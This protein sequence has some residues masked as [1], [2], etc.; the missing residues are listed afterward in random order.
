MNCGSLACASH[1]SKCA[2][3]IVE[4]ALEVVGAV[5]ATVSLIF[6][7]AGPARAL[8]QGIRN[9]NNIRKAA[10]AGLKLLKGKLKKLSN[11]VG[12]KNKLF[13]KV[14]QEMQ[15]KGCEVAQSTFDASLEGVVKAAAGHPD[16]DAFSS[17][18]R[19]DPTGFSDAIASKG[20]LGENSQVWL[21]ALGLDDPTGWLSVASAF[22]ANGQ[23]PLTDESGWHDF[24]QKPEWSGE[25]AYQNCA[26][27]PRRRRA[28]CPAET[29]YWKCGKCRASN[30]RCQAGR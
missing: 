13:E 18:S 5:T 15:S 2:G 25:C 28:P 29:P 22:R 6:P 8:T 3:T 19:F 20:G 16:D 11:D 27:P 24:K 1:S 30:N 23:C 9:L 17:L 10:K 7:A 12:T 26:A 4:L 21:S 14:R